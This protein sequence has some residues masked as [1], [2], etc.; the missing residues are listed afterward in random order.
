MDLVKLFTNMKTLHALFA[1][2]TETRRWHGTFRE[3]LTLEENQ[4]RS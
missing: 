3:L 2:I 1:Y 4:Q